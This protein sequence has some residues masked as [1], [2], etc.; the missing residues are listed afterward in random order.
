MCMFAS[1][2]TYLRASIYVTV[3]VYIFARLHACVCLRAYECVRMCK[4]MCLSVRPYPCTCV[5]ISAFVIM[6]ANQMCACGCA[7][8]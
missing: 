7:H 3:C 5:F 2:R 6:F 1:L 4:R 8:I